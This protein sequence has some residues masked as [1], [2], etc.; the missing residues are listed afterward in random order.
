MHSQLSSWSRFLMLLPALGRSARTF[1]L[2]A[3]LQP[4]L[5]T[6]KAAGRNIN[7]YQYTNIPIYTPNRL[8][9][10]HYSQTQHPPKGLCR[11]AHLFACR[12][13]NNNTTTQFLETYCLGKAQHN[14][15]YFAARLASAVAYSL[16]RGTAAPWFNSKARF[17]FTSYGVSLLSRLASRIRPS[18]SIHSQCIPL[19]SC[20]ILSYSVSYMISL[21][22]LILC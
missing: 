5:S 14:T 13:N 4:S 2:Q 7:I 8:Q 22:C 15:L 6:K 16:P 18:P 21:L 1:S 9:Q 12:N 19:L 17:Y 20:R 10:K 3:T 11:H